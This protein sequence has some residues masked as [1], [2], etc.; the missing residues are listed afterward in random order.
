MITI[1][2]MI[3]ITTPRDE[4]TRSGYA[5]SIP[6]TCHW[7]PSVVASRVVLRLKPERLVG[8]GAGIKVG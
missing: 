1:I 8:H 4:Q 7:E 3:T 2:T 6:A 5:Q